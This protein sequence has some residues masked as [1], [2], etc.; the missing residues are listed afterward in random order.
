MKFLAAAVQMLA[1]DDKA[2]NLKEAKHWVR[3]AAAEG[4]RVVALPE[5]FIWRGSKKLERKFAE[6][7]PGPSSTALAELA[8]ECG[9]YLLAGSILEEIPGSEKAY[10]TSLL[11]DPAGKVLA[12]YRKIHLFDVDLANGVS[13]RESDTRAHGEAMAVIKTDLG[14][15]GLSVCYDLRF[16]ELYR[17]LA[18]QGAELI[19]VPSAFTAY[20]GEAHWETLLRSRAIENQVYIIAPDQFGKSAK[21]FETH[22][23]SIIVD[24]WGQVI[25]ELPDGPGVITAEIDLDYLAKV[26]AELP[27]LKHRRL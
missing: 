21:S 24:P 4:A 13:L 10:N 26:R 16:P 7:I 17:G 12:S 2:A 25:A 1:S 3:H 19:F 5:V 23:H 11:F 27:A 6:P 8:S 9:I 20:T 15:M 22:G 14:S 18:S